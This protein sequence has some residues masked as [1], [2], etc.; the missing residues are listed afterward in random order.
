MPTVWRNRPLNLRLTWDE[1]VLRA[2][3]EETAALQDRCHCE[4]R[5]RRYLALIVGDRRHQ[6]GLAVVKPVLDV[7]ESL[8]VGGPQHDDLLI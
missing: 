5:G 2:S 1:G 6:G 3:V 4:E 8:G 7:A